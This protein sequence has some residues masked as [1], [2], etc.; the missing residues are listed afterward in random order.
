MKKRVPAKEVKMIVD[1]SHLRI[2]GA[3]SWPEGFV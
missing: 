2:R 3:L 1:P